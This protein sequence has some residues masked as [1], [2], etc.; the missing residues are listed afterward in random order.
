MIE[1]R[2][3]YD[4]VKFYSKNDISIG[5]HLE[6]AEPIIVNYSE[7]KEIESINEII[8]LYNIQELMEVGV[9]LT[10]WSDET[11]DELKAKTLAFKGRIARFFSQICDDNFMQYIQEVAIG[12]VDDF[13]ILFT[14]FK[15]YQR[16][17]AETFLNYLKLED[18]P[19]YMILEHKELVNAYDPQLTEVLRF[20]DQTCRILVTQFLEESKAKYYLPKTFKSGEFERIFQEYI[21]SDYVNPNILQLIFDAQSTRECPISNSLRLNAKRKYSD[22]WKNSD[23]SNNISFGYGLGVSF[24]E[25]EEFKKCTQKGH[26]YHLTYD[27][28]WLEENLDY[29]TILNNFIYMFE[30]FDRCWRSTLVSVKSQMSQLER[31]FSTKGIKFYQK[32]NHFR[33]GKMI[34]SAQMS[35]YYEFLKAHNIDLENVFVWFFT[36]YLKNEFGAEG[37]FMKASTATD[38][39]E[40][41]RTLASEMEGVLKQYRMFVDCGKI[42]RELFEISSE[43]LIFEELPS[44]I[45]DKYAYACSDEILQE[46]FMLFSDQSS[47][48]YTEQTKGEYATLFELLRNNKLT[49]EDFGKYQESSI[50]WL[51]ER[52]SLNFDKNGKIVLNMSR[53]GL[54]KDL[55]EHDVVCVNYCGKWK[56]VLYKM[57]DSGDVKIEGKLFSIPEKNFL[58]YELNKSEYSDGLDLR[59]KYSH[60]TYPQNEN[61]QKQDYVELLK[62]MILIIAKINEEFCLREEED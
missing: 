47:L 51:I 42:D 15:V 28:K 45:K 53:V 54:L 17:S 30:M 60:S 25:Q 59:N 38:C 43:H 16:V 56:T 44:F 24:L 50:K 29:P 26:D 2:S 8:E 32:G 36:D 40:K 5:W 9:T 55:Y 58:N 19:L 35:M 27:I 10:K 31:L 13:W 6:K 62:I 1:L 33:F 52:Q 34:S 11:Y 21:D 23:N 57:V 3:D 39:V 18:T 49:I 12:Y 37:F 22:Y 61:V 14:K 7:E 20:S 48:S 46:M 4:G 41:C